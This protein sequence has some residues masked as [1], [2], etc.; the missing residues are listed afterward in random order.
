MHQCQSSCYCD[1]YLHLM[2]SLDGIA[3]DL[4]LDPVIDLDSVPDCT[5][6]LIE[7]ARTVPLETAEL[8]SQ[9]L[10]LQTNVRQF[11]QESASHS[12]SPVLVPHEQI[13]QGSRI[14]PDSS[15]IG[16]DRGHILPDGDQLSQRQRCKSRHAAALLSDRCPA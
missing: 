6:P 8:D 13:L 7:L 4:I 5:T 14:F 2:Q 10:V 12:R 11:L 15:C 16:T 9:R 3:G 1:L